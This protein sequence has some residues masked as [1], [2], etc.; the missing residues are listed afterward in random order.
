MKRTYDEALNGHITLDDA[1]QVRGV[2]HVDVIRP[3]ENAGQDAAK[4]YLVEVA[5]K[6]DIAPETLGNLRQQVSFGDPKKQDLEY[7]LAEEKTFF[8]STTYAY[9]QTYLN[10][11]VWGAGIT[12]TVNHDPARVVGVTNT[13][14]SGIDATLPPAK[15]LNRF[16]KLFTGGE[17]VDGEVS[18]SKSKQT[19]A[20]ANT[21]SRELTEILSGAVGDYQKSD[22]AKTP[23]K[24]I[25]GRFFLYQYD[26][27]K[28]VGDNANHE[29]DE[30]GHGIVEDSEHLCCG[31]PP[32][33]PLSPVAKS[34]K[35]GQWCFAAEL[36]FRL[37][38][39]GGRMNWRML[40]DVK[41]NTILY[42]RALSSGVSG[43][44]FNY[45]PITSTGTPTNTPDQGNPV[46][47]P[48][49]DSVALNN[50]NP[51][52][53]GNQSLE[54][55]WVALS[56]EETPV[57]AAPTQPIGSDFDYNARTDEFAAVNAYYHNDRFFDLVADLGFPLTG[58]GG[59]FGGTS[60]PVEVDHRGLGNAINAHCIGDGDGIDHTCYALAD[61][62][63]T[64]NPIG[65]ASDWRV[66][67]HELGGHGILYD[68]VNSANFGFSHSAG[69]SFAV[70]L[71]DYVS[72]WHNGAPLDRFILAPF[73]PAVPRRSDRTVASGWGWGGANDVGGYSSEQILSTTLFRVYRSIGGDSSQFSRREFAARCMAYL[74][75]RAVG[76]L[77]PMSNPDFPAQFLDA[78][79]VADAG[80]W[81]SEGIFG[82]AYGKVLTWSFEKQDLNG[83]EPPNV[84]VYIDDG[85]AGE[86]EYLENHW[87]TQTVWNRRM[88]DGVAGHQEPSLG[89]N[90]AYVKIKNRG[91]SEAKNVV[92]KAFHC[93]PLAGLVWPDDLQSMS[94]AEVSVGTLQPNNAEEKIVGPFAWTPVE[95][96]VG[97]DSMFMVVS[98]TGDPSNTEQ[99]VA[100]E[101]AEDWR[102]VPNDNNIALRNVKLLPRL[103]TVIP[104]KGEFGN[105]CVGKSKDM[106]L[107]LNNGGYGTL[108]V[109]NITAS[110]PEFVTPGVMNYPIIIDS[111]DSI[112]IPIRFEP[113]SFGSK[114]ATISVFSD[115][116]KGVKKLEVSGQSNPPRLVTIIANKGHFGDV[117]VNEFSDRMLTLSNS[118]C[119]P[120]KIT[121]IESSHGEFVA[122]GVETFPIK[123]GAGDSV[124]VPIRFAANSFGSKSGVI[125]V[126]SD[127]PKGPHRVDVYGNTPAGKLAVTGSTCIGGVKA[128]C[129][130]E[131]T[132]SLCN[133]GDCKLKVSSVAFK[134]QSKYWKLVN[135]P[136]PA[137]L[138]PGSCLD[139][140][141]RYHAKEKCPKCCELVIKSD[142]PDT[143]VKVLDVMA[144]TVWGKNDCDRECDDC[145]QGCCD[146]QSIDSCCWDEDCSEE[147]EPEC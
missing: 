134:R 86:Y 30:H 10:T 33:I 146:I 6:L 140:L 58:A 28:R 44:V 102:L 141:I 132:I 119:C 9:Y 23:P 43:L 89:T 20:S 52:V 4:S 121:K 99:F 90:Y 65:I 123:I 29:I 130:G 36:V 68:H 81:A 138:H 45:D 54:G 116:P 22:Y 124:Q 115:D 104:D 31:N 126:T 76:T 79:L 40:V 100:G 109:S 105:V 67:L 139:V 85:R 118:G 112:D 107:V 91:T 106:K 25:R 73:V 21:A 88:P 12:I 59:Y 61:A 5:A 137:M 87:Q 108:A 13:S 38:H 3:V 66:V 96:A 147:K 143:P 74:M 49:R 84:D 69:D 131:R 1:K 127:D 120:L 113:N 63:D 41:T 55:T 77:T 24:L 133:T 92:V 35:G 16:R 60:F 101:Q 95:N 71:N 93:N 78:L 83:G 110:S 19:K 122:P 82:G 56:E 80:N 135:S 70:I 114:S 97:H 136:F 145:S 14:F 47:N 57:V 32:T 111:G 7:R 37:P 26:A 75:L 53:G 27:E 103:V 8:D 34:I 62:T 15:E 64:A 18:G 11:P 129:V 125:K 142:D 144:Y 46:L 50:L 98:A 17:K 51:P 94:T 72:E 117:C 39:H 2:T 48:Q 128:C 42:L